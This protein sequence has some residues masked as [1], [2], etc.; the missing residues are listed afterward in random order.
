MAEHRNLV[1]MSVLIGTLMSAVDTTIVILAIPSIKDGLQTTFLN[2]I[3]VILS[4]LLVLAALTTQMGRLGD[5]FGR[6]R[7]FNAGFLVFIVGSAMCGAAPRADFLIMSRAIQG[8]GAVLL[9]ANGTAIVADHF[10]PHERGKAYGIVSMGWN[11]GG[12]L[13]IV[14]G[15]VITTFIGWRYIFYINVPIGLLGFAMGLKYIKDERRVGKKIDYAGTAV[16][17]VLLT[18]IAY[19]STDIA[20]NGVDAFNLLLIMAGILC[21]IPFVLVERYVKDPVILLKAFKERM[22]TYSL[23]AAT[24][25]AIGY[26]SVIF[27]LI[28]YLQGIRGFTPLESSLI[29]VPGY[30]VSG[31]L[32]PFMGRLADRF[33][34]GKIAT[35]GIFFMALGVLVY[36]FLETG[37]DVFVVITGSLVAGFGGSMFWPSNSTS[38]MAS[39]PRELY[40]SISGLLR[41]LSSMGVLFSYVL[42]ISIASLAVPRSVAF[43]VF[44][45]LT[46]S[47]GGVPAGFMTGIRSAF[48]TS[49]I[50]LIAAGILSSARAR[51][52]PAGL[53]TET[54]FPDRSSSMDRGKN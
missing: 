11:I 15:G 28:L 2:T 51:G 21:L 1:L 39:A 40:G 53:T 47:L 26:L 4:Y 43:A 50:I 44:L 54:S 49:L 18:L 35:I 23:A 27:I 8:F 12:I 36:F 25:Q 45:G 48:L 42:T 41:T 31:L 16:L 19:G 29:L 17:L 38:V 6:R 7:I 33:G 22:L 5:I 20:G 32:S 13:G 37:S 24:L 9:Q 10:Q 34:A 3:W 30:V 46:N 52:R 14:L